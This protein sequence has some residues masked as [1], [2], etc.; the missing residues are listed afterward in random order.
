MVKRSELGAC[1][2]A[3]YKRIFAGVDC[4]FSTA[5][6]SEDGFEMPWY[7]DLGIRAEYQFVKSMSVW[8]R[9]GNLLNM[10]I[11]RDLM[12]AEKGVNFTAGIS[13]IF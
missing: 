12:Y 3:C 5:R 7:A 2:Y 9:G 11:Q 8:V 10:E 13:L 1:E 4:V 6:R